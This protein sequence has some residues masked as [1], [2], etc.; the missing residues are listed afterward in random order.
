MFILSRNEDF[1]ADARQK[2]N[3]HIFLNFSCKALRLQTSFTEKK[4]KA[5]K[6]KFIHHIFLFLPS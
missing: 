1:L 6:Y 5:P 3:C 2:K 4:S